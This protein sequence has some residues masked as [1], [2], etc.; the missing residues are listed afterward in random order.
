MLGSEIALSASQPV[1]VGNSCTGLMP[2]TARGC[3]QCAGSPTAPTASSC[4]RSWRSDNIAVHRVGH[5][6]RGAA[7]WRLSRPFGLRFAPRIE[8][9][10][11]RPYSAIYATNVVSCPQ[12]AAWAC[13]EGGYVLL[14]FVLLGKA[15]DPRHTAVVVLCQKT[16]KRR[17]VRKMK[18]GPSEPP[19]RGRLQTALSCFD[20]SDRGGEH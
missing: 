20:F 13:G 16:R 9:T 8:S 12:R 19:C 1:F 15:M 5:S 10:S 4:S 7:D 3:T 6:R 2:T 11:L 18:E 14:R 17:A